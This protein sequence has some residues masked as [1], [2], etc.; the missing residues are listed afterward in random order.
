M[1][2]ESQSLPFI[3]AT[4]TNFVLEL[5]SEWSA[6]YTR[7]QISMR[8]R[9]GDELLQISSLP[10]PI[11]DSIRK[12]VHAAVRA[13][14]D[15]AVFR[16]VESAIE[17]KPMT[18]EGHEGYYFSAQDRSPGQKW[19]FMTSG[20]VLILDQVIH[21]TILS[22]ERYTRGVEEALAA[23]ACIKVVEK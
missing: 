2:G 8:H 22:H 14:A 6:E 23:V 17:V 20:L 5:S 15:N 12:D 9:A 19:G 11:S 1:S 7:A 3:D 18:G 16:S 10:P 21:F 4:G 13:T